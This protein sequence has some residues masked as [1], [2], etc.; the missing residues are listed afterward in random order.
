MEAQDAS[1][2]SVQGSTARRNLV[3]EVYIS[4]VNLVCSQLLETG[5]HGCKP[6][7]T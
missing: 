5:A 6:Q 3:N 7:G 1:V 4:T 2:C